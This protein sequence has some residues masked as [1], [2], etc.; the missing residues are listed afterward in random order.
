M[1]LH[2][3][4]CGV[5]AEGREFAV[6][7]IHCLDCRDLQDAVTSVAMS[8]VLCVDDREFECVWTN[9]PPLLPDRMARLPLMG[10]VNTHWKSFKLA[11][12]RTPSHVIRTWNQPDK[13]P[14]CG[15]FLECAAFPFAQWD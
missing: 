15:V 6:Q 13:C 10:R 1:R 14:R 7:T 12:V 5:V 2:S 3:K 9:T 11:C 8:V 4:G